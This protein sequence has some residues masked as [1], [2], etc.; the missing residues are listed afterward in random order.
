MRFRL[1]TLH[2]SSNYLSQVDVSF[3]LLSDCTAPGSMSCLMC[4]TAAV[5][6]V[7]FLE[8]IWRPGSTVVNT[9]DRLVKQKAEVLV[10]PC[11]TGN[12]EGAS[13]C[14]NGVH[15]Q[16]WCMLLA[17]S[18]ILYWLMDGDALWLGG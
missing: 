5:F 13:F 17:C 8:A 9:N 3:C 2:E 10:L 15:R 14:L 11:K 4:L 16:Q 7:F 18:I 6:A 1:F 12:T